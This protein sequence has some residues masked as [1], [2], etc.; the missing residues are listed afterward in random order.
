[1]WRA[2]ARKRKRR[3]GADYHQPAAISIVRTHDGSKPGGDLNSCGAFISFIYARAWIGSTARES[4]FVISG[5][6][7]RGCAVR[8]WQATFATQRPEQSQSQLS[9]SKAPLALADQD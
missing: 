4:G 8:T 1:M 3:L 9:L 7:P 2:E 5:A 6:H